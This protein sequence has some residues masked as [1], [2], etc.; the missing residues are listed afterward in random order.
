MLQTGTGAGLRYPDRVVTPTRSPRRG[1]DR[2]AGS[3]GDRVR[4][5]RLTACGPAAPRRT[6]PPDEHRGT[7]TGQLIPLRVAATEMAA[8]LDEVWAAGDAALPLAHD[9]SDAEIERIMAALGPGARPVPEGTALV[10]ATSGSTGDPKGVLLSHDA[11]RVSTEAS[12]ARLGCVPGDRWLLAL[13]VHHVAGLQVIARARALGSEPVIPEATDVA[14]I[15]AAE[16]DHVSLVPT[17]LARLLDAGVDLVRFRTILLGGARPDA[18]LLGRAVMAGGRVV[19]SYGM[20]ET[21][22]G[23]VYDGVPLDGIE[24][25]LQPF[26]ATPTPEGAPAPPP[27]PGPRATPGR[28]SVGGAA[29]GPTGGRVRLRGPMLCTGYR[30]AAGDRSAVDA[31]GWFT[32]GDLGRVVDGLLEVLGRADDVVISG[33]ENVP[34]AAVAARL[35]EHP[36]VADAAVTGRPDPEWGEV[37]VAVVVANDPRQPPELDDLRTHVRASHPPAYAPRDLVVVEALPR[38]GMGK[39][40]RAALRRL[41]EDA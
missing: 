22:G 40:P 29:G 37:V 5:G 30:T 35:R 26:A 3:G 19:V 18:T 4:T 27:G 34:A 20:T 39:V 13:P 38:D 21:C 23:C 8:A 16:A 9:G 41:T 28:G 1:S 25:D 7:V 2:L 31:E 15:A 6:A 11:L 36:A 12:L 14:A 10:V 33:G 32:T 24:V 17:Q